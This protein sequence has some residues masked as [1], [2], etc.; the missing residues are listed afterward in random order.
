[1][2]TFKDIKYVSPK[3]VACYPRLTQ[4]DTKGEYADGKYKVDLEIDEATYKVQ[5][6]IIDAAIKELMEGKKAEYPPIFEKNERYYIRAK[7]KFR[8]VILDASNREIN[9]E[10]DEDF[11]IRGGSEIRISGKLF[12]HKKGVSLQL[13]KVQVISLA[14]VESDFEDENGG[15]SYSATAGA[16][17]KVSKA[18]DEEPEDDGEDKSGLDL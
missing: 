2:A 17:K 1:M 16:A 6:K 10:N 7:S 3:G 5:K 8:P 4:P 14:E 9:V 12:A 13:K 11:Y 18:R 15:F